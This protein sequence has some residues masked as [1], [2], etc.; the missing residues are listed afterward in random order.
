MAVEIERKFLVQKDKLPQGMV[1]KR[2]I[3][4]YL[5][6]EKNCVVRVRIVEDVGKNASKDVSEDVGED[7]AFLTIKGKQVGISRAEFEYSIPVEEAW[8]LLN[9]APQK[10]IEKTR[11]TVQHQGHQWEIDVFEGVNE[12]LIVAE[13][14]LESEEEAFKKPHWLGKEVSDDSRYSNAALNLTPYTIW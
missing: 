4:G 11:Y 10:P 1:G 14:E 3:Q 5:S 6:H 2:Y 9:L 12:G 7:K 13:I 8:G